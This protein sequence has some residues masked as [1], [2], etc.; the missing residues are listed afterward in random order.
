MSAAIGNGRF[1][2]EKVRQ[3]NKLNGLDYLEVG[4]V[5]QLQTDLENQRRLRVYFLNKVPV[6]LDKTN[7]LIAG[8]KRVRGIQVV[9]LE[10]R[11]QDAGFDDFMD[12]L[13]D[14]AGDFS[15]YT[16]RIIEKD[17][18]NQ[19]QPHS[20]FDPRYDRINFSFK[21][22]C[23]NDFDCKPTDIC[24]PEPA[25][26]PDINYLAKDYAS[27]RQLILDRLALIMPEWKERHVPDIGVAL[28]EVL[29]YAADHLS[30]YQDAVAT[31]AYLNAARQ[32]IS[33]RRHARLVD[34]TVHEGCNARAWVCVE[35]SGTQFIDFKPQE[36]YFITRVSDAAFPAR[37]LIIEDELRQFPAAQYEVFEPMVTPMNAGNIR[38]YRD[39][40]AIKFYTW[41]EKECCLHRSSISTTLVGKWIAPEN[42]KPG[43][44]CYHDDEQDPEVTIPAVM[45]SRDPG[46][47]SVPELHLRVGDVL[48][49]QEVKGPKTGSEQDADPEHRHAV[50]LIKIEADTD[51]LHNQSITHIYWADE[52]AL[53]F[54]L[55]LSS[56]SSP[57]ECRTLEDVSIACGNVILADHGKTVIEG[58]GTVPKKSERQC[59]IGEGLTKGGTITAGRY[60][61][62]LSGMPLIFGQPLSLA[63]PASSMLTQEVRDAIPRISLVNIPAGDKGREALFLWEDFDDLR[64]LISRLKQTDDASSRILFSQ[65]S[66]ETK[67]L[68]AAYHSPDEIPAALKAALLADLHELLSEWLPQYDLLSSGS[69]DRHFVVEMDDNRR[70]HI[71]FGNG[72]TGAQLD[73]G[74]SFQ[75]SYRVGNGSAGNAGA[76]AITHLVLRRTT[77]DGVGIKVN[78]PLPAQGGM[79]PEPVAEVKLFAP[80]AF[81][82]QLQRAV[83]ADDY[84]A[85]T[86]RDFKSQVQNAAAKLRWNGSWYEVLTAIDPFGKEE[87]EAALIDQITQKLYR[88]RRMGHDLIVQPAIRVPLQIKMRICVA[89]GFLRGHV[90]AELLSVF[91]NKLMVNGRRGFFHPDELSFGS[92]IYLSRLVAAAQ[93]VAG[94]E[95]VEIITFQRLQEAANQEIENGVLPL[96]PFEI[97]RCDNDPGFPEYG[98]LELD[99][100]GG[101]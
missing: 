20:A 26:E 70:A 95:S 52:D 44:H 78:N 51:P 99:M 65:L 86:V 22:D 94:V 4:K 87:A 67:A 71:R 15:T 97:A 12:I 81:R 28:V 80:G 101:R 68:I 73:A 43:S 63:A 76:G 83:I 57:P 3:N 8:G 58:L 56:M 34:Y 74:M 92:D 46:Q 25:T 88:Y 61:P 42:D 72:K 37:G 16:L 27:F 48:I 19:S 59:C 82:K 98:R 40:N 47:S 17:D 24:P 60:Q 53:P 10:V 79:E 84:A 18:K 85:I 45:T 36:I 89:L 23:P 55:C 31:E 35:L 49:F 38:V 77:V 100:R 11:S 21:V 50:R 54:S 2:R 64:P 7:I 14:K 32:R 30:Y 1:R 93:A 66:S 69:G 90:K 39:H 9:S 33:V 41:G 75:A 5:D 91:G 96:A 13:V 6:K 62:I 29:A